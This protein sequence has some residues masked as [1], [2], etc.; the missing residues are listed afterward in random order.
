MSFKQFYK[1]H[2]LAAFFDTIISLTLLV[3]WW[4]GYRFVI[5]FKQGWGSAEAEQNAI[6]ET[7][8]EE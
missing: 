7:E 5:G 4:A 3:A 8:E 6:K 2:L 1:N